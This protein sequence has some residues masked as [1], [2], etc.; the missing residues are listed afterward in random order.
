MP[1]ADDT[2]PSIDE[3]V[4]D[5]DE[6]VCIFDKW[7]CIGHCGGGLKPDEFCVVVCGVLLEISA[8]AAVAN[9]LLS[10]WLHG[11]STFGERI[12][13]AAWSARLPPFRMA[14]IT[15]SNWTSASATD[16]P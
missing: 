8:A 12:H 5:D 6:E 14:V 10:L 4:N 9:I 7:P 1:A 15:A 11:T 3:L 13:V 2:P 16:F